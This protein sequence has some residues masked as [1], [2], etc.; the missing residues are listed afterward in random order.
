MHRFPFQSWFNCNPL[1]PARGKLPPPVNSPHHTG[2]ENVWFVE[3]STTA[4]AMPASGESVFWPL[5]EPDHAWL[6]SWH[7]DDEE[8]EVIPDIDF[9]YGDEDSMAAELAELYSYSEGTDLQV[10][11]YLQHIFFLL[12][13][14]FT[15]G[16]ASY[17][18]WYPCSIEYTHYG[19]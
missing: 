19:I 11:R 1:L 7:S 15:T 9:E 13:V 12:L 3:C 14:F 10:C 5:T 6:S 16:S 17:T 8:P 2:Q 4:R 18:W